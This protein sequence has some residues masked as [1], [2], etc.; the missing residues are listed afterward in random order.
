MND[1]VILLSNILTLKHCVLSKLLRLVKIL[2]ELER[3]ISNY[4]EQ[5]KYSERQNHG[6]KYEDDFMERYN[7]QQSDSY[8][9][10]FDG[11]CGLL[12]IQI[13]YTKVKGEVC[14]G[15]Y[16][17]NIN[18]T[19]DFILHMAFY[20]EEGKNKLPNA[21]E[22]TLYIN[23]KVYTDL[24]KLNDINIIRD[25]LS[26]ISNDKY[27]DVKFKT[28][29][30]KYKKSN[31]IIQVR[32][33]RDHKKQKRIQAA[34]PRVKLQDFIKLFKPHK[35]KDIV[36][37]IQKDLFTYKS[38]MKISQIDRKKLE[39]FYTKNTVVKLCMKNVKLALTKLNIGNPHILE[40][41]AGSGVFIDEFGGFS[42][43]AYDIQP[44]AKNIKKA[45]FLKK[46]IDELISQ[47]HKD[48][49]VVGNPPYKLA[50][51]FI[52]KCAK[53]NSRLICFVLPN[54]FKKP[55]IIN[56]IDRNYHLMY[57]I[58]LPKNSFKLGDEDYDVPS[59]FFIFVKKQDQR[60]LI[61]LD[62]PCLGY[63]YVSFSKL[64]I[65]KGVIKGADISIIR[66]GGR[67]G[68]AF[69]TDDISDDA[70]VSKQKYNYFIKLSKKKN[71]PL[72][73]QQINEIEW[74]KN[75]TTGPRS[76]GKYELNPYLNKI[77][78]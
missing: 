41:S 55:T 22:Y 48:L 77:I 71:I 56:K 60:P 6:F 25:E 75:N 3:K 67:A 34:I 23:H 18:I 13:K 21:E 44:E 51:K 49:I 64:K 24:F 30:N 35:F 31:N 8:T 17:R 66:V 39:K 28:F 46:N 42:Y 58:P 73:I 78:K 4:K 76:I 16:R 74:E 19:Q 5:K 59:S 36:D 29:R 57:Q 9:S 12:P 2:D 14:L 54:V 52:N 1:V 69:S 10:D 63:E 15:D 50:V 72:I 62:K 70:L 20:E 47:E 27:D 11:H 43:D 61:K 32:F 38:E 65:E 40:P 45:D 68:R 33:K 37:N 26:L 53:L 7:L